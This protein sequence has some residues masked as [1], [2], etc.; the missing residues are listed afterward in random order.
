VGQLPETRGT[1]Q[2][3]TLTPGGD[4]DGF[5]LADGTDVD[6]PP[7]LSSQLASAIRAGD[8]V[9]VRGYR[10]PSVP[11]VVATAV[12][13][14]ATNQTIIDQGP[15]PPG[16]GPPPPPPGLP[17]PGAQRTTLSGRVQTPLYGPM[18]DLNGAVLEDGTI[19]RVPPPSAYQFATLLAP[20]QPITVQGWGLS[21]S[22]GRVV[23]AQAIRPAAEP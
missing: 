20:G 23:E 22:Y 19:L 6:V 14:S 18:G 9:T 8:A 15:P 3:F 17:A 2:R 21:N 16:F 7:H 4:L 13:D 1:V 5:V 10:S 11:L 12:T